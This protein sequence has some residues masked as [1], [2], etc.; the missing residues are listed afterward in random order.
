MYKFYI[1]L[2]SSSFFRHAFISKKHRSTFSYYDMYQKM[3][4]KGKKI[5]FTFIYSICMTLLENAHCMM[6]V[7]FI[8]P[9]FIYIYLPKI[10][11][12]VY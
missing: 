10:Q 6:S 9:W 3:K 4:K 1:D 2:L 12:R 8:F 5:S 11:K 7:H